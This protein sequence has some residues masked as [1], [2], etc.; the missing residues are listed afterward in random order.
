[1]LSETELERFQRQIA[2]PEFG[3][4]GQQ[5]LKDAKVLIVGMGGLG[6]V[7]SLF[8]TAAGV[9]TIGLMDNDIVSLHNL[10]RQILYREDEIGLPK[11]AT[12]VT[13]LQRLNQKTQ[14][15]PY[16]YWLNTDNA[17]EIISL[18]DIV[19]DCTD[20]F[21][22]RYL[23]N[24]T[25]VSLGKPFIYGSLG[26]TTGQLAVLNYLPPCANYRTLFPNEETLVA[27]NNTSNGVMGV[28]PSV[29]ASLQANEAIKIIT[30]TGTVMKDTLFLIDLATLETRKLKLPVRQ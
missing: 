5:L 12:A 18:Y 8:L 11:V 21:R 3:E 27:Q 4:R 1:M 25:C 2:L 7:A 6:S 20:N 26:N 15:I 22:A 16:P 30:G 10:Q 19:I 17:T 9:G 28:L 23:I 13:S 24:D 29:I 14:F